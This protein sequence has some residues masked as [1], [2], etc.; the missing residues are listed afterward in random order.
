[1]KVSA[2]VFLAA[3]LAAAVPIAYGGITDPAILIDSDV[4]PFSSGLNVLSWVY[5][6]GNDFLYAYQLDNSKGNRAVSWF[7]IAQSPEADFLWKMEGPGINVPAMWM[8][9]GGSDFLSMDAFF[10]DPID[11]GEVSVVLYFGSS[12]ELGRNYASVGNGRF[13]ETAMVIAPVPEPTTLLLLGT[14]AIA[15]FRRRRAV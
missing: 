4:T 9:V 15:V 8:P 12:R 14:G 1:M 3:V 5:Q 13:T 2:R 7:S 10:I 6:S 11:A